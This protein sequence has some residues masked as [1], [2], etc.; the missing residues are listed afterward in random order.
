VL[1]L[2]RKQHH[3]Q[4]RAMTEQLEPPLYSTVEEWDQKKAPG[5]FNEYDDLCQKLM[6]NMNGRNGSIYSC[7][8]FALGARSLLVV[9]WL[10]TI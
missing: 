7:F 6:Q 4:K 10:L 3:K 1:C 9:A 8:R 5:P 2:T